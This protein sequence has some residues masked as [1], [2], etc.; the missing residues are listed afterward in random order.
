MI[1][2]DNA[3]TTFPKPENVYLEMDRINREYAVNAGRGAYKTAR[4]ANQLIVET[5]NLLRK[6]VSADITMDV[7]FSPSITIA[8]NQI[9][10][11]YSW[12][13]KDIIYVSPYEHNAVARTLHYLQKEKD[14]IIKQ[15]PL[16]A[17]TLEIDLEKMKYEFSKEHYKRCRIF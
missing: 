14:I 17:N 6:L 13:K 16:N 11:G 4:K 12:K 15:L 5:K 8:L 10:K 3:A 2:L 7:V 1:Y 9:I